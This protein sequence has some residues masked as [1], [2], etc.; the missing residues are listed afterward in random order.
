[1]A[2]NAFKVFMRQHPPVGELVDRAD[3]VLWET[4]VLNPILK[5]RLRIALAEAVGCSYCARVRTTHEGRP[6]LDG[7]AEVPAAERRRIELVESYAAAVVGSGEPPDE[8]TR[9]VQEEF[10]AEEFAD[11]IFTMS[12]YIGTQHVGRLMHWDQQCPVAPI[13]DMVESGAAA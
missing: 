4:T 7:D 10:T 11:L 9:R 5:E 6:I 8:M 13:R 12:W 1:M 2:E 3:A